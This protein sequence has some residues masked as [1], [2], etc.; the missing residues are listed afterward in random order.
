MRQEQCAYDENVNDQRKSYDSLPIKNTYGGE[1]EPETRIAGDAL[2][3]KGFHVVGMTDSGN[4]LQ[5]FPRITLDVDVI[6]KREPKQSKQE[7]TKRSQRVKFAAQGI[8][9]ED[10]KDYLRLT[11]KKTTYGEKEMNDVEKERLS[12]LR[13]R[14]CALRDADNERLN[15]LIEKFE[16]YCRDNPDVAPEFGVDNY[17]DDEGRV[18]VA[19]C[20]VD[21]IG[22]PEAFSEEA[23]SAERQ[24][25]YAYALAVFARFLAEYQEEQEQTKQGRSR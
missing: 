15:A 2:V 9:E 14:L 7:Q 13:D 11:E 24:R 17:R 18:I 8:P 20:G 23:N 5:A 12:D 6:S 3:K 21:M 1:I 19:P 25:S 4:D 22:D 16:V 10:W